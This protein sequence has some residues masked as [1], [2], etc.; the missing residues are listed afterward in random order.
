VTPEGR[1]VAVAL[2]L[3]GIGLL[4]VVTAN[5]AA[6]FVEAESDDTTERLERIERL[7]EDLNVVR[8]QP[9]E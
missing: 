3:V 2:M 9:T 4:S 6:Y 5:I 1:G 7:L 8:D